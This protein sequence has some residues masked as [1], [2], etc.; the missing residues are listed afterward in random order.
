MATVWCLV[1]GQG[2]VAGRGRVS[3][4]VVDPLGGQDTGAAHPGKLQPGRALDSL[5][6][7][8]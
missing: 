3:A 5:S 7:W 8:A 1:G 4:P 2:R 6:I